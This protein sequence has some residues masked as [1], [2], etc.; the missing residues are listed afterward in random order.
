MPIPK[1][2]LA[3]LLTTLVFFAIDLVW[4]GLVA[5]GFYARNMGDLLADKVKWP[6]ALLFY[7]IYIAGI[8]LFVVFPAVEKGSFVQAI[9]MGALLGLL[10]YATYDLTSYALIKGFPLNVVVVDLIW[11]MVLTGG[12]SAASFAIV[13]WLS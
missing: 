2:L 1:I 13:R 8:M 12:V 9:Y 4:L 10:C 6:A 5:K 11:G 3:F 7:A